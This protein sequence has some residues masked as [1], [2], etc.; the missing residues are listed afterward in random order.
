[1]MEQTPWD[2]LSLVAL[3]WL[4]NEMQSELVSVASGDPQ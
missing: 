4:Q 1:M 2:D 3:L